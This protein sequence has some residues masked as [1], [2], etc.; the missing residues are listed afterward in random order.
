MVPRNVTYLKYYV[1]LFTFYIDEGNLSYLIMF[2]LR[3]K[4]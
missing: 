2:T 3:G 1:L 4:L